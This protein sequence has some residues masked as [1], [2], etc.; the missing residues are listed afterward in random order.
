MYKITSVEVLNQHQLALSF[1]D[2]VRGTVDLHHLVGSGVFAVWKDYSAFRQ[3]RIGDSG[4]L[5]WSENVDLCP[6]W[7]YLQIT[8]K[9]AA[10]IFPG[11]KRELANA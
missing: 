7:L 2:G 5:I 3:V 10:E 8:G 6:D 1:E 9:D 11:L 4:E